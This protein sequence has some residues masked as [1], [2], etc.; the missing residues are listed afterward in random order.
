MKSLSLYNQPKVSDSLVP[1]NTGNSTISLKIL[2]P[3][4]VDVELKK[5]DVDNYSDV[6]ELEIEAE[7]K[8]FVPS[9]CYLIAKSK[10]HPNHQVRAIYAEG[11]VVGL[12]LYQTGDG[13]FEPHECEIFGFIVDRKYQRKG[14]GKIAM[15]LLVEEIK[16]HK[17]FTDIELSCD[18]QN[19]A[20]EKVYVA[21]G[22]E[23]SGYTKNDGSIVYT[24]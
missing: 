2:K 15:G 24:I 7:Q 18:P 11:N 12:V 3:G 19:K 9:S 6:L 4:K 14:I 21:C 16:T 22:F 23:D 17:Q 5:V 20:A 13:D 1:A 10:F 8:K